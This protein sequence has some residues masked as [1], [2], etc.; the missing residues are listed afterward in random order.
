MTTPDPLINHN[1][2]W[3]MDM[4][5]DAMLIVEADGRILRVNP[6]AS[7]L[8]GYTQEAMAGLFIEDLMPQRFRAAHG[9]RRA[10]YADQPERRTMGALLEIFGLRQCGSEF[11]ADVSIS[12][13]EGGR[14]LA[15]VYDISA[16]KHLEAEQLR[17]IQALEAANEELKNFAYV[18]SH[19]LKAPLRAIGSLADWIAVDQK[20]RMDAEG[21]EHLGLLIQRVR[22][23]D[24]LIDGVLS[25]SRV[26]RVQEKPVSIDLQALAREVVD[27]LAPPAHIVLR[28]S[29]D[30]PVIRAEKTG[31]QQI[32]Q[33][34][35]ANAIRYL[36]KPQGCIRIDCIEQDED[37]WRISVSD[38]GPGI[39]ERHFERIFQLFQTL[40]PRDRV[41]STGVG[42]SIV[43]KI[44]DQSGGRIWV[45]STLGEGSTF[46][47][48]VP[49]WPSSVRETQSKLHEIDQPTHFTD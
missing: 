27:S 18:V 10:K 24:A 9:Q 41:E 43:K 4:A 42:L 35:I 15:T 48:T 47:F 40:N 46:H 31:M 2:S 1:A 29:E 5:A 34:L 12:P 17:M 23:L 20:D 13:I 45:E 25:Y 26:G 22:R 16:R 39:A 21:Q 32:L 33:N 8:F 3:L 36:D 6:A 44:V 28:V 11:A 19:D 38:N 37:N 14:V 7:R 49:K 30:L